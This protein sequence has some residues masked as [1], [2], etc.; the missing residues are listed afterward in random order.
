MYDS[1]LNFSNL[2]HAAEHILTQG[3]S[4]HPRSYKF[5]TLGECLKL[6]VEVRCSNFNCSQPEIVLRR[7]TLRA[8]VVPFSISNSQS[9]IAISHM[10]RMVE[11][12]FWLGIS[13]EYALVFEIKLRDDA[14]Y[15][16]SSEHQ[17][18]TEGGFTQECCYL[19]F[20]PRKDPVQ[21][22]ILRTDTWDAPP[23]FNRYTP[24]ESTAPLRLDEQPTQ[25]LPW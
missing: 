9:G 21:P 3:F 13:T 25:S 7:D 4:G 20:Y 10:L 15:F 12:R 22:E 6:R 14:A 1:A 8:I 11:L 18:D 24:I 16:D 23:T 19:T 2:N 17:Q 5:F